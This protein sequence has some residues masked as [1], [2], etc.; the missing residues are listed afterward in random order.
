MVGTAATAHRT[1]RHRAAAHRPSST[2]N[3][4]RQPKPR[5]RVCSQ[6]ITLGRYQYKS[7]SRPITKQGS[8]KVHYFESLGISIS[9]SIITELPLIAGVVFRVPGAQFRSPI[10]VQWAHGTSALPTTH[11]APAA[12]TP[13]ARHNC[14]HYTVASQRPRQSPLATVPSGGHCWAEARIT[15][16]TAAPS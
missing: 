7:L 12:V 1:G 14:A 11:P 9:L 15:A 3:K 13:P 5:W 2:H 10:D 4:R 16:A 8:F 6:I